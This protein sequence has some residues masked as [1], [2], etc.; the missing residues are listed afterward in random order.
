MSSRRTE[1]AA[2]KTAEVPPIYMEARAEF[3]KRF[4]AG[5][6][7]EIGGLNWP[8]EVGPQAHVRQVDRM[9][10]DELRREY[11]EMAEKALLEVD[12]VDDGEKLATIP[13]ESQDFIIANHFLEHTEDPIGTIGNHLGKLKPGGVLFYAVPDKRYTFDFRRPITPLEHMIRDHE[14]DPEVSRREHFDEWTLMVGGTEQDRA[15]DGAYAAFEERAEK[16]ARRLEAEDFS[17]HRHVWDQ[18]SFLKLILH[19]R[20]RFDDGFDI[21]AAGHRSLEFV[22]VLRKRGAWPPPP[23][24]AAAPSPAE[25]PAVEEPPAADTPAEAPAAEDPPAP[26][27][28]STTQR[29]LSALRGAGR[30]QR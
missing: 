28:Q 18:G 22:V 5:E 9:T 6:G 8:L 30:R 1:E 23:A 29:A 26:I 3:A 4:L 27:R 12:I 15:D 19:C 25:A 11:P 24:P 13:A 2:A 17:I 21:E 7:L 14:E 10:T 16:E 20:E